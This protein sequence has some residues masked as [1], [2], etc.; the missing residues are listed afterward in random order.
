[1]KTDTADLLLAEELLLLALDDERGRV[2]P[3]AQ[4]AIDFGLTGALLME[5]T[6]HGA[7]ALDGKRITVDRVPQELPPLLRETAQALHD[8]PGKSLS[9]WM[10]HLRRALPHLRQRLI[11]GLVARGTLEKHESRVLWVFRLTR[12]PE[13]DGHAEH[14]IRQRLD[15]VLLHGNAADPRTHM[16][17]R[18]AESCR[19]IDALYPRDQRARAKKQLKTLDDLPLAD[20]VGAATQQAVQAATAAA[21]MV[22][23]TAATSAATAS[24]CSAASSSC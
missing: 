7:L 9:Y 23:I 14:D 2:L 15:A 13:R 24:A 4:I 22:A 11:D 6:L 8:K 21:A 20:S 16:L 5:L 12:Y 3:Q 17:A 10:Q 19:L 1:M 18:L